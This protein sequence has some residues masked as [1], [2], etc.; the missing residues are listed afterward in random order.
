MCF[1]E[2]M[3]HPPSPVL[4]A[5]MLVV[6]LAPAS[7]ALAQTAPVEVRILAINDFHGNLRPP[8]GGIRIADPADKAKKIDV[9]AAGANHMAPL[10]KQLRHGHANT[11]FVAA[12]DLIGASPF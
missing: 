6:A 8:P 12:G 5:L 10:A 1:S 9:P 3:K 2:V 4:A 11:I 7:R